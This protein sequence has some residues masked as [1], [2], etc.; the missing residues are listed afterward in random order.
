MQTRT[1]RI[2]QNISNN[3]NIAKVLSIFTVVLGHSHLLPVN[4]W[5]TVTIGLLVFSFSSGYFTSFKYN[6]DFSKKEFWLKK[7]KRLGV[8]L[9]VINVFLLILFLIQG[10]SGIWTWH[11]IVNMLGLNGF[12]NWFYIQNLSPFGAGLWFFTLLLV[13]YL[14]YPVLEWINRNKI[15]SYLFVVFF[16]IVAFYLQKHIVYGH[17]LWLTA[18][19]FVTGVFCARNDINISL[20][21]SALVSGVMLATMFS[22]NYLLGIK[23]YNFFLILF[24]AVFGIFSFINL[25]LS[26]LLVVPASYF[27]G[28]LLEIYLIHTY[29]FV[30]PTGYRFADFVIS[31]LLILLSAKILQIISSAMTRQLHFLQ[32]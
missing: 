27:S 21:V 13:F 5:V 24:L 31:F 32:I 8:N 4:I 15:I 7:A 22:L 30:E 1:P 12:L 9:I 3:F 16:V 26:G 18:C 2:D 29:L 25:K 17:A 6:G 23:D 14:T 20:N 11:T 28:C 19:G 10:R